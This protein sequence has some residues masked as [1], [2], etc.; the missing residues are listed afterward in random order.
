[1]IEIVCDGKAEDRVAQKF[2]PLVMLEGAL[3]IFID[4]RAVD[5][6]EGEKLF[7]GKDKPQLFLYGLKMAL[8][9][10][11]WVH[12][13]IFF[14]FCVIDKEIILFVMAKINHHYQKLQGDYLFPEIER[15][16]EAVKRGSPGASILNLGIGDATTPLFP[17]VV[18]ALEKASKEMGE[19][20]SFRG[21][22]PS[23]GYEFL[24]KAIAENE[25]K[26]I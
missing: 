9:L 3:S 11:Q 8:Q 21:Y 2:E 24:R 6:S 18:E 1:M 16:V 25:Y 13:H 23:V 19:A 12:I 10:L 26:N 22:G 14:D 4:E 17:S 7:V 20:H 15:R 5:K